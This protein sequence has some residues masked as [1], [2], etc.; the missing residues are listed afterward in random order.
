[1]AECNPNK[2]N[3][4]TGPDPRQSLFL[5]YYLDPQSDTFSNA[6]QSGIKAGYEQEYAE[7]MTSQMPKWLSEGIRTDY[8]VAKAEENL[9]KSL[10]NEPQDSTDKNIKHDANKFVL[11]R[12]AKH[13]YSERKEL[14]G[15][16][17]KPMEFDVTKAK[18][19]LDAI[20]E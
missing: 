2:V 8:L 10:E 17:G 13:K 6:L 7:T 16:E 15:P 12:L 4:Y 11:T 20:Q 19:I 5:S 18:T 3:Q 1:M 9:K 14:T